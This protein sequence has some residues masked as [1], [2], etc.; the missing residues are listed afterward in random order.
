MALTFC[1]KRET[2]YVKSLIVYYFEKRPAQETVREF[3]IMLLI[4]W[5]TSDM[6]HAS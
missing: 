1:M 5:K 6:N 4:V 2:E 3:P